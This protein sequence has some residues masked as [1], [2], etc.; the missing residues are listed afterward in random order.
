MGESV[1]DAQMMLPFDTDG[2]FYDNY[3][4][5]GLME[6]TEFNTFVKELFY[7][8]MTRTSIYLV[9]LNSFCILHVQYSL[10]FYNLLVIP[11]KHRRNFYTAKGQKQ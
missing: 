10:L 6:D 2:A 11:T 4:S 1:L 8:G 7:E 3:K 5:K 9:F